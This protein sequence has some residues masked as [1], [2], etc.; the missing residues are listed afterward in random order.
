[1]IIDGQQRLITTMLLLAAAH[2]AALGVLTAAH[3]GGPACDAGRAAGERLL[4]E[5]ELP[6]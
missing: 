2:D 5:P 6:L 3:A 4:A 1:M